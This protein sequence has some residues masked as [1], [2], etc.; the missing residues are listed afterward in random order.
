[1]D[2][3]RDPSRRLETLVLQ[4]RARSLLKHEDDLFIESDDHQPKDKP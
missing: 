1:V 4:Q 3:D 2:P